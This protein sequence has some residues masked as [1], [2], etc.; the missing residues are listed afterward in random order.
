MQMYISADSPNVCDS[1]K[2]RRNWIAAQLVAS[3]L[4]FLLKSSQTGIHEWTKLNSSHSCIVYH[5]RFAQLHAIDSDGNEISLQINWRKKE[6]P[7][8]RGDYLFNLV[9]LIGQIELFFDPLPHFSFFPF[10][11][12]TNIHGRR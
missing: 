3:P 6:K 1:T 12:T 5:F 9:Q 4:F 2:S 11:T 8:S 7:L 10:K